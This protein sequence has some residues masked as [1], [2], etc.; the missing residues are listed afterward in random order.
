[1]KTNPPNMLSVRGANCSQPIVLF[2][3]SHG[4]FATSLSQTYMYLQSLEL[5]GF[6]SFAHKTVLNFH[7]GR[8]SDCRTERLRKIESS[9]CCALGA[10]RAIGQGVP[11]R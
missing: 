5:I 3:L 9:G 8:D 6:K 10:R 1:M 4:P 7:H 11:R 2:I